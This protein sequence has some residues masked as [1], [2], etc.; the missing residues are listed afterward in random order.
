MRLKGHDEFQLNKRRPTF[1]VYTREG[2]Y[3]NG[4]FVEY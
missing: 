1:P 3:R 4:R 2:V